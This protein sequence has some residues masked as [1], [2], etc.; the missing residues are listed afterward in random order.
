MTDGVPTPSTERNLP[1]LVVSRTGTDTR[2]RG[3]QNPSKPAVREDLD[4]RAHADRLTTQLRD[5]EARARDARA[6]V[7][8]EL[9]PNGMALTVE[10]W[11]DDPAYALALNS[12]DTRDVRLLMVVPASREEPDRAATPER[13][14]VWVTFDKLQVFLR[15]IEEYAAEET[16]TGKPKNAALVANIAQLRLAVLR[17]LWSDAG[18]FPD[19]EERGWWE[20]WLAR[21][22]VPDNPIT[23]L[24][25][26]ARYGDWHLAEHYLTLTDR[27]VTL[28]HAN[29]REL[30]TILTTN[31]IPAELRRPHFAADLLE[32]ERELQNAL[33][34]DLAERIDPAPGDSPAVCVLD[35]G[36]ASGHPL[37]KGS[38]DA[39]QSAIRTVPEDRDGHGTWMAGLSLFPD[40][41]GALETNGRLRL[42]HR[43]E[44]VKIF[45]R[46][47]ETATEPQLFGAVTAAASSSVEMTGHRRRAYAMA[48][49]WP[50]ENHAEPY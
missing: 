1:H 41:S 25:T 46:K 4:R 35:T 21:D 20:L 38:L 36:V 34:H 19:S 2:Y 39:M 50:D 48:I 32:Q 9:R 27:V 29:A 6:Q 40:L 8:R 5:A 22:I 16:S 45:T 43:L 49:T 33:A 23:S 10:G 17:E 15:K 3:R 11:S 18:P 26:V 13:A 12:L 24:R 14:V 44:S 30:S 7:S 42:A 37:L 47:G 31:A 28:V